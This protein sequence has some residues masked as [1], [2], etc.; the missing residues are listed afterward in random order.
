[1]PARVD[2][3]DI[4][5]IVAVGSRQL[6]AGSEGIGNRQSAMAIAPP[7]RCVLSLS[8]AARPWRQE[9]CKPRM[10]SLL[11]PPPCGSARSRSAACLLAVQAVPFLL[12]FLTYGAIGGPFESLSAFILFKLTSLV[13]MSG[14]LFFTTSFRWRG[15][16]WALA[17]IVVLNCLR[18]ALMGWVA[19]GD[20]EPVYLDPHHICYLKEAYANPACG[21]SAWEDCAEGTGECWSG[22]RQCLPPPPPPLQQQACIAKGL[23]YADADINACGYPTVLAIYESFHIPTAWWENIFQGTRVV[24]PDLATPDECQQLCQNYSGCAFFAFE[25]DPPDGTRPQTARGRRRRRIASRS[26][27]AR[28]R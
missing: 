4:G 15:W 6:A 13:C 20:Y 17:P 24:Q 16:Y 1:M 9:W 12:A 25:T 7:T 10:D 28:G 18:W 8:A 21:F 19:F 27:M 5:V 26:T 2:P 23:D 14:L 22:P 11:P 3:L